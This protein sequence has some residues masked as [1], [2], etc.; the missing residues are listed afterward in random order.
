MWHRSSVSF[1]KPLTTVICVL[2]ASSVAHGQTIWINP[3]TAPQDWNTDANWNPATFPNSVNANATFNFSPAG[4]A[5]INLSGAVTIGTLDYGNQFNLTLA[6]MPFTFDINAAGNDGAGD[7]MVIVS[8][9][10]GTGSLTIGNNIT[11]VDPLTFNVTTGVPNGLIVNGDIDNGGVNLT[12]IGTGNSTVDGAISGTGGL[13]MNGTGILNLGGTNLFT[14]T[15]TVNSGTL[16]L[17][18]GNAIENASAVVTADVAGTIVMLGANEEIGSLNGGGTTGGGIDLQTFTL[19]T[20]SADGTDSFGGAITST[21]NTGGLT[22]VG[23]GTMTLTGTS[24]YTGLTDI[25]G[26][27]LSVSGGNAIGDSSA[28]DLADTTG[29]AL[30]LGADE[31]IGSLT[32]GGAN[33]GN[34][35]LGAN[36]LTIGGDGTS[37]VYGG[38]INGTGGLTKI[39]GGTQFLNGTNTYTGATNINGGTLQL[40]GGTTIDDASA[41]T[42]TDTAATELDL[43]ASETI[44]SLSGGGTTGGNV[45]LNAN[46]LTTGGNNSTTLFAGM[47]INTAGTGSLTKDGT[48]TMT[49]SGA[50]NYDGVTTVMNGILTAANNTA[51]GAADGTGATQTVVNAGAELQ[52]SGT[53]TVGDE[54]LSITG[55]GNTTNGALFNV[56]N[57]NTFAGTVTLTGAATIGANTN[58]TLTLS[59]AN[60]IAAGTKLLTFN[61][62]ANGQTNVTG[63]VTGMAGVTISG[64]G[65]TML[66]GVNTYSGVTTVQSGNV[67]NPTNDMGLGAVGLGNNTV[68]NDGG[69]LALTVAVNIGE[70]IVINGVGTPTSVGVIPAT[71]GALTNVQNTATTYSGSITLGSA[72]TINNLFL[73]GLFTISGTIGN[74]G[75]LLTIGGD[76]NTTA[77][78]AISGGGGL[79]KT[80]SGTLTLMGANS[81][82]GTTINQGTV[83]IGAIG[84]LGTAGSGIT[85]GGGTLQLSADINSTDAVTL[86]AGGGTIETAAAGTSIF[87]GLFQ[88]TGALTKT[89]PGTLSLSAANTYTGITTVTAGTL[90]FTGDTSL[91][92]ANIV[93]NSAVA[94]N[95][96]ANSSF[97][98]IISG[99]GTVTKDGAGTLSLTGANTYTGATA[100]NGG[101]LDVNGSITSAT[102]VNNG[103][104]LG[105]TGTITGNVTIAN[106]GTMAPGNSTGVTSVVGTF[107][108][109]TGSTFQLEVSP[110]P[111]GSETAG[112][113]H[114]QVNVTGNAVIQT[115]ATVQVLPAAGTYALGNTF[116]FLNTTTGVAGTYST[117]TGATFNNGNLLGSLVTNANNVQLVINQ[118]NFVGA[119]V[120]PNQMSTG[121]GIDM[122]SPLAAADPAGD[123]AIVISELSNL[124]G[125]P[126]QI[127]LNQIGAASNG[128]VRS[129]TIQQRYAHMQSVANRIR[130]L[131]TRTGQVGGLEFIRGQSPSQADAGWYAAEGYYADPYDP[132][133][134]YYGGGVDLSGWTGWFEGYGGYGELDGNSQ[135]SGLS[136]RGGGAAVGMHH[137]VDG[138]YQGITFGYN[139]TSLRVNNT[140]NNTNVN[141]FQVG[142]YQSQTFGDDHYWMG[143]ANYGYAEYQS[144]RRITALNRTANGEYDGHE[145]GAYTELGTS[146][147]MFDWDV[148]PFVGLQYILLGQN[149]FTETGAGFLNLTIANQQTD[150][151]RHTAGFRVTRSFYAED[152]CEY[153][154]QVHARWMRE[155]LGNNTNV[156]A[157]FAGTNAVFTT[158]GINLPKDLVVI[159][160]GGTALSLNRDTSLYLGFDVL[161]GSTQI[162]YSGNAAFQYE[163]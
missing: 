108:Q 106:G 88:G 4:D 159:G 25:D 30:N 105:G 36:T 68:V 64:A 44:G 59:N 69:T 144:Q 61:N 57:D 97:G 131:T 151:L 40:A 33:G 67:L 123:A 121:A 5:Q 137:V 48:G 87:S 31:T 12:F 148:Q 17:N 149:N 153:A 161:Y 77:T 94:F 146:A 98:N 24:T 74:T 111:P 150:S 160:I 101:R 60:A 163:W 142:L 89:G 76:G 79:L 41:V 6:N 27:I 109:N 84:N 139:N 145:F 119:G 54:A 86:N 115:G 141:D 112:T 1:F 20:G 126:L 134:P 39:N 82:V 110:V 47:I 16:L 29:V 34:V 90:Q 91:L 78:N 100:V 55:T 143:I 125:I 117:L 80:G 135:A 114:D 133:D 156:A 107:N 9:M 18:N 62:I 132:Y 136:Y 22:K 155:Y 127:A 120:T 32:G 72:A 103:G 124:S 157:T 51:L 43:T 53:I 58:T 10:G 96:A 93:D 38:V 140:L 66:G 49:L 23:T 50:N 92:G 128:S 2:V 85:F 26:G 81:Y 14:G 35:T 56:A 11:A 83:S 75:N 13:N 70:S 152:G 15:T 7:A 102:T 113:S 21:S 122:A 19:T 104:T 3:S 46:T 138:T 65:T 130:A 52:L 63:I 28:V 147:N 158:Q 129:A 116:T 37:T 45:D 154:P 8:G 71:P 73:P 118:T 42:L 95:Q 99:T 162:E